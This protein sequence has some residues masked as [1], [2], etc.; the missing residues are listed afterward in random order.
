MNEI[1]GTVGTALNAEV[2][3][4]TGEDMKRCFDWEYT[5]QSIGKE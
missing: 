1:R 5:V 3:P 2:V 4:L